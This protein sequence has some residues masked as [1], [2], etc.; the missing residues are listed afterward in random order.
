[1]YVRTHISTLK[2]TATETD[3][4]TRLTRKIGLDNI[5][6]YGIRHLAHQF[7]DIFALLLYRLRNAQDI[8]YLLQYAI[9]F[10]LKVLMIVDDTKMRM[11][12][13]GRNDLLIQFTG[14]LKPRLISLLQ[15]L[16]IIGGGIELLCSIG[17]THEMKHCIITLTQLGVAVSLLRDDAVPEIFRKISRNIHRTTIAND[18]DRL[19]QS[20]CHTGKTIL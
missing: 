1:M 14:Y 10:V 17:S 9:E 18:D 15:S 2:T 4:T 11:T 5:A 7:H 20:L 13:P 16:R 8:A 19:V 6:V 12:L 3:F